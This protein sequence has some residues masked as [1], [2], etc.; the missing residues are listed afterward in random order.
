MNDNVKK[1][2]EMLGVEPDEA[3]KIQDAFNDCDGHKYCLDTNL[4]TY[5]IKDDGT[6]AYYSELAVLKILKGIYKIVKLSK[7]KKLRD[8]TLEEYKKWE[9]TYCP[10]IA[11]ENCPFYTLSCN[12]SSDCCWVSHKD[13]FSDKFLDQEV[14]IP[15]EEE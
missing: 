1:I 12:S 13:M 6:Q 4:D 15:Q 9:G 8:L 3:F 5:R 11:C 10:K 14:E 2:F 7:T